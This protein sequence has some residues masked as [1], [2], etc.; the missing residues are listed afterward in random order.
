MAKNIVTA[1]SRKLALAV[2]VMGIR[3]AHISDLPR[4]ISASW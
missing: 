2:F 1:M 3:I 4:F